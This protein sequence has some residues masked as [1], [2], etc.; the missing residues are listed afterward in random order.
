MT[1]SRYERKANRLRPLISPACVAE[2]LPCSAEAEQ[3]VLRWV[4]ASEALGY[5]MR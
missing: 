1:W 2:D 4:R 5:E 3:T